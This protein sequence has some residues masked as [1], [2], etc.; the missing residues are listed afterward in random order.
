MDLPQ[1]A[2]AVQSRREQPSDARRQ[3]AVVAGCFEPRLE[4]VPADVEIGIELP[5]GVPQAES[6]RSEALQVAG[7]LREPPLESRGV[8]LGPDVA[9]EHAHAAD[10][11]RRLVGLE[12]EEGR[13]ERRQAVCQDGR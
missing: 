4:H 8:R 7:D 3:L 12:I 2:A 5:G 11:E 13:V 9:V 6:R 1:R 10:V